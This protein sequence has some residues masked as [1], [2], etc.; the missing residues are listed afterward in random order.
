MD[1]K[2]FKI[3]ANGKTRQW[4]KSSKTGTKGNINRLKLSA[5]RLTDTAPSSSRRAA[6]RDSTVKVVA[7][8]ARQARPCQ[9]A[10]RRALRV[11][12]SHDAH[13]WEY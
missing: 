6:R 3:G 5:N 11:R 13:E 12:K 10:G 1:L 2:T 7:F 8:S 9:R 4:L